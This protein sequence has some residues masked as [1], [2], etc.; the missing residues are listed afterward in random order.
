MDDDYSPSSNDKV[1][2]V[3]QQF[4][5]P[6]FGI[7]LLGCSHGF[8][9]KGSTSG[10]IIWINKRGVMVDPPPYSTLLLRKMG[11]PS[12]FVKWIIISHTHA[13]HDAGAF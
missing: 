12:R 8:D 1:E 7:T 11:I 4:D 10:Y 3:Q 9:P 5:P 6:I 13:D 2:F